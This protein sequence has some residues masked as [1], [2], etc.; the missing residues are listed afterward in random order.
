MTS[1][2][3]A[4][5]EIRALYKVSQAVSASLDLKEVVEKI[6]SILA[7]ELGM[8]RGT[9][10]LLDPETGELAIEVA[11]GLS[12]KEKRRG[13]YKVGEG[14]TGRVLQTG[15]PII[16]PNVG[17]EPLFLNR[18]GA[19]RGIDR[20]AVA[21]LCV[22]VKIG[23]T[24]VGVLSADRLSEKKQDLEEDLT[25]L[26]TVAGVVAQAVRIQQMVKK[27]KAQLVDEN[28]DLR[29]TLKGAFHF[30]NV[31]GSSPEMAAVCE[32]A[33]LAGKSNSPILI[34]GENGVGKEHIAKAIHFNSTRA[35]KP[36]V[37]LSCSSMP[38][39]VLEKQ[40]FG[41]TTKTA[42]GKRRREQGVLER[43]QGGTLFL[44]NAADLPPGLQSKLME[45]LKVKQFKP[46]GKKEKINFDARIIAA[47]NKDLA[48]E[49]RSGRFLE[50]LYHRL[51]V[52]PLY[53]PPLRE[54]SED[55]PLLAHHFLKL[56]KGK[57]KRKIRG[58]APDAMAA[59]SRHTW[60][61]NVR[62][63]ESV[64]EHMTLVA[65]DEIIRSSDLP[66]SIE[67]PA[68]TGD[69]ETKALDRAAASLAERL[70]DSPP[71]IGVYKAVVGR[72]ERVLLERA[73]AR[74][75]GVRLRA[76]RI[77]GINRNTMHAKLAN[78]EKN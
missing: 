17:A 40:L 62:E 11:H 70:F 37:R 15:E 24:T 58:F 75:D 45:I 65:R 47:T 44:D 8:Q 29:L 4:V 50:G 74:A 21:F 54:R 3:K 7:D 19:R 63:L 66:P 27:E 64:I 49:T 13:R 38:E 35:D 39:A 57:S 61:G 67:T 30:D 10:S 69:V 9:L 77:L 46:K 12:A 56:N 76:A 71:D 73:L 52:V 34:T 78:L 14:I 68:Q 16:I 32:Q 20:S 18:T 59:L 55:A 23:T 41:K 48:S 51:N 53:L 1:E 5:E 60:P 33:H 31:V 25:L 43:A 72:V 42:N 2:A 22:P 36:F 26:S 28:R 6:L